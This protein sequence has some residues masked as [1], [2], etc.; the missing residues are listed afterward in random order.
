MPSSRGDGPTGTLAASPRSVGLRGKVRAPQTRR[1]AARRVTELPDLGGRCACF[2][3]ETFR[4]GARAAAHGCGP[5]GAQ[6]THRGAGART[7]A[8]GRP[9]RP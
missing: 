1:K 9:A 7:P 3:A 8:P 5:P 4:A 6:R 2:D